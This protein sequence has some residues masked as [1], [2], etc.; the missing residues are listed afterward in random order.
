MDVCE[1]NK[2]ACWEL[3]VRGVDHLAAACKALNSHLI[4]LSTD[5]VFDGTS[6]P[7]DEA[8]ETNPVNLYGASKL[9]SETLVQ[10]RELKRWSVVRTQLVFG[11]KDGE[12][13]G[14]LAWVK[15]SLQRGETIHVV[16]DQVRMPT[17]VDDLAVACESLLEAEN[18]VYHVSGKETFSIYDFAVKIADFYKLDTGLITPVPSSY[19][20]HAAKRPLVTGFTLT[21]ALE[22]LQLSP[23]TVE[24][25]LE[26]ISGQLE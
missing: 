25:S 8:D 21:K 12:L 14:F 26:A 7:Y 5:F 15:T 19:F 2:E 16:D 11:T 1:A 22:H 20:S 24:E 6:G 18:G 4:Q 17:F 9:A 13:A 23:H 3:N 10:E